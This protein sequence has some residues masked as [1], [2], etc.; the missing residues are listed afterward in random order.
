MFLASSAYLSVKTCSDKNCSQAQKP[1]PLENFYKSSQR[2][3]FGVGA[4]C[5]ECVKRNATARNRA[6]PE[7]AMFQAMKW[8][9]NNP[10]RSRALNAK[11]A[12]NNKDKFNAKNALRRAN[13]ELATPDWL[14]S[15]DMLKINATYTLAS[16]LSWKTGQKIEVDHI[17]PLKG[18]FV[19]GL[20]VPWN[21]QLL[22][23][24]QNLKKGNRL[25]IAS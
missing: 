21:L 14:T 12:R 2:H 15:F 20:H 6:N 17:V 19:Q 3:L 9:K 11:Y 13:T 16:F 8:A 25:L 4:R 7:A 18:A 5:K 1:Q 24:E 23:R 10:E 22:T